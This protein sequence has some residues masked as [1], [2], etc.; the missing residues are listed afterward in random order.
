MCLFLRLIG[1]TCANLR[2]IHQN[3]HFLNYVLLYGLLVNDFTK[4]IKILRINCVRVNFVK[5]HTVC[6]KVYIQCL[7]S[8]RANFLSNYTVKSKKISDPLF[9]TCSGWILKNS[10]SDERLGPLVCCLSF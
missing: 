8:S 6:E 10:T 9:S 2:Q 7:T 3:L 5:Y 4:K 1:E